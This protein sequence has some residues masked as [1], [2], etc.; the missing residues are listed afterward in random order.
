MF[1]INNFIF[2]IY[3]FCYYLIVIFIIVC[4]ANIKTWN[5]NFNYENPSNWDLHR[6]PCQNDR[7]FFTENTPVFIQSEIRALQMV[8]H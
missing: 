1:N 6:L 7:I 8:W 3:L 2:T 4:N 5:V